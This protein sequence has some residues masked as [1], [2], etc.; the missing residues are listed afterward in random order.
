[1]NGI[2]WKTVY[3]NTHNKLAELFTQN[4]Y[5]APVLCQEA[6]TKARV[7]ELFNE[8][9]TKQGSEGLVVRTETTIA[10]KIKPHL[11]VDVAVVG[12]SESDLPGFVRTLLYALRNEDGTF[13]V[14]GR[15]GSGL[16]A[17][18]KKE[19]YHRL[20]PLK[21]KSNYIETDS[22]HAVF[23]LIK[24][25]LVLE[26]QANDVLF[27]NASG[28]IINPLLELKDGMF[29]HCGSSPGFS[30]VSAVIER[31]RDDKKC[32]TI[33]VRISQISSRVYNPH[34]ATWRQTT[35][36]APSKLLVREVY[37][38]ESTT[39]MVMKFL[40]W[41]TNKEDN[42][43]P[44]FVFSFTNFSAGKSDPLSVD[45]RVSNSEQQIMRL[46]QDSVAKNVKTGWT[47]V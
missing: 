25:A 46:Y 37:K 44:S 27:E 11:S 28:N 30:L 43:Y 9:V 38:K 26:L 14:I 22:N 29:K 41:K 35:N 31:F 15:T 23:H 18:Q 20:M 42:N 4:N 39:P 6:H 24:P 33:D 47:K 1:V 17:D 12:F 5:C 8:W 16:T 45:V 19:L 32:D 40:V 10:V 3:A 21:I 36:N 7:K 13:Q 2:E 34:L